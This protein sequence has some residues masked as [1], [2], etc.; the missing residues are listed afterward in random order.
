MREKIIDLLSGKK[1]DEQPAFSG[2]IH[3]MKYQDMTCLRKSLINSHL[4]PR[5]GYD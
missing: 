2:L 1:I 5:K 4:C 3:I